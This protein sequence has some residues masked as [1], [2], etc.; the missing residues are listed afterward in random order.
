MNAMSLRLFGFAR[1]LLMVMAVL[2]PATTRP[3]AAESRKPPLDPGRTQGTDP[4]RLRYMRRVAAE[5][6]S[7]CG[8]W[9][10]CTSSAAQ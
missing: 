6:L 2:L 4:D 9:P 1:R 5:I 7:V 8:A 10:S 3:A